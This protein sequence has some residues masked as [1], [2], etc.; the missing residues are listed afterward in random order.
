MHFLCFAL[1]FCF[2]V[3]LIAVA[4]AAPV[5]LLCVLRAVF[6][7]HHRFVTIFNLVYSSVVVRI[8]LTAFLRDLFPA[9]SM[10]DE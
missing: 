3:S 1:R 9:V 4:A 7:S 2:V 10:P 6:C 5:E 8:R